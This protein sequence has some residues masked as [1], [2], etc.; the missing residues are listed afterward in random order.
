MTDYILGAALG[1][2]CSLAIGCKEYAI[3]INFEN[4]EADYGLWP[5]IVTIVAA[6][7]YGIIGGI[8]CYIGGYIGA[9][10]SSV[11]AGLVDYSVQRNKK[12]PLLIVL[13]LGVYAK[14]IVVVILI[15]N[16]IYHFCFR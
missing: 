3:G 14:K 16:L 10:F 8:L 1:M 2:C 6:L 15:I 9:I 7:C 5:W 4:Y 12:L 13:M 11:L